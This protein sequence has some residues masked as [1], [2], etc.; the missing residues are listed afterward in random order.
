MIKNSNQQRIQ[1]YTSTNYEVL[2]SI[3]VLQ[4]EVI[5]ILS[6][7]IDN[8]I[9]GINL[10]TSTCLTLRSQKS[11]MKPLEVK[12]DGED[13]AILEGESIWNLEMLI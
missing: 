12:K 6:F 8:L 7:K 10:M 2:S 11:P 5:I 9:N 13:M 3:Q 1:I 4:R